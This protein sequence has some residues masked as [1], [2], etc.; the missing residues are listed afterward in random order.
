[1]QNQQHRK[2]KGFTLIELMIVVAII[3]VL[4]AI[5]IP[6]YQDYV[7]KSEAASG[8]ATL[9]ALITP[10]EL[11]YQENGVTSAA[12]LTNL[13]TAANANSLGTLSSSI[14]G[15]APTLQFQF[16]PNSSM[17]TTDTIVY[18]RDSA[19]GWSCGTSGTV[20]SLDGC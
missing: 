5:A 13:G 8:L 3:G 10:A 19:T 14:S 17:T 9:K 2:Q 20:P 11:F 6:A 7:N 4:A 18:T 12:S 1:M 15:S 16:G